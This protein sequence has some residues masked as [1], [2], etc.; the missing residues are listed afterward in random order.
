[1]RRR[2]TEPPATID[3]GSRL[4]WAAPKLPWHS[5][6]LSHPTGDEGRVLDFFGI[7]TLDKFVE[8]TDPSRQSSITSLANEQRSC[9]LLTP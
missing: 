8:E 4:T 2:L 1:M 3:E 6:H 7:E 5:W 9:V